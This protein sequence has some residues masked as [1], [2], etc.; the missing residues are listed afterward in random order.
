MYYEL[1]NSQECA[2]GRKLRPSDMLRDIEGLLQHSLKLADS[3]NLQLTAAYIATTIDALRSE[4]H[5]AALAVGSG[6]DVLV[7]G[8]SLS[9]AD[10]AI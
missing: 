10:P 2:M 5:D 4:I 8:G 3:A 1:Q 7:K 6:G 9:T